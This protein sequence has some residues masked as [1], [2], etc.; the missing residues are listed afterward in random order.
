MKQKVIQNVFSLYDSSEFVQK[1]IS[2]YKSNPK[3]KANIKGFLGSGLSILSGHLFDR[4]SH[5]IVLIFDDKEEA[6]YVLNDL[7]T[8]FDREQVLFFPSSYKRPYEVEEVNN[9]NVV[10]RTEVLNSLSNAKR[11]KIV[12]TYAEALQEKVVTKKALSTNTL[13]VKV[14]NE[15]GIDFL[16][17]VLISYDF[18][19]VDFVSEPGEFSIRGGIVDVF[20]FSNEH[21][22][23]ISL[24]G[25]EVETIR[26][27][28]IEN[29]LSIS[30]TK[31]ITDRKSVV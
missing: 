29:Q 31:D 22:Y 30:T 19:K 7:E 4:L 1:L 24:F 9:A 11:H 12:V 25:D 14:G 20:S 3:H 23:R 13:K 10:I 28:D 15:L 17:E 5:P 18:K 6:A 21:P 27:F 26:T 2:D 8:L 16:T